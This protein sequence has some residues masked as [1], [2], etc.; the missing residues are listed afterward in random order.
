M[1]SARFVFIATLVPLLLTACGSPTVGEHTVLFAERSASRLIEPDQSRGLPLSGDT[2]RDLRDLDAHER[3]WL[4]SGIASYRIVIYHT[5]FANNNQTDAITV[6]NGRAHSRATVCGHPHTT[7][8]DRQCIIDPDISAVFTVATLF[9]LARDLIPSRDNH[10]RI[11]YDSRYGFPAAI[12]LHAAEPG[13]DLLSWENDT[14]YVLK[15]DRIE[16]LP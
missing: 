9:Q 2:V 3:Q 15:V 6:Y 1:R 8:V 10:T 16:L 14:L 13:V 12:S 4:A 11:A 7:R 5:N